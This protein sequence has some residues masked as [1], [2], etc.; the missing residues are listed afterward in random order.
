MK[1]DR[2]RD[3][4]DGALQAQVISHLALTVGTM[5]GVNKAAFGMLVSNGTAIETAAII[6]VLAAVPAGI[7]VDGSLKKWLPYVIAWMTGKKDVD[8]GVERKG[9]L[10]WIIMLLCVAQLGVSTFLNFSVSPEIIEDAAGEIDTEKYDRMADRAVT[11]YEKDMGRIEQ[12]IAQAQSEVSKAE[13]ARADL[14]ASAKQSK[15]AQMAKLA[16]SGNGWA[17]NEI[18]SAVRN[19]ER[20]GDKLIASATAKLE[21]EQ[22]R[23]S[24]YMEKSGSTLDSV[25][26]AAT[27]LTVATT[28]KHEQKKGRWTSVMVWFMGLM[29]FTFVLSTVVVVVLEEEMDEDFDSLPT[30]SNIASGVLKKTTNAITK[31]AV[32][33]FGLDKITVAP[34]LAGVSHSVRINPTQSHTAQEDGTQHSNTGRS[35]ERTQNT[36]KKS[37]SVQQKEVR[38]T[39]NK[40]ENPH[41]EPNTAPV[42]M[43][44]NR[45]GQEWPTPENPDGWDLLVKRAREWAKQSVNADNKET[46]DRNKL[47]WNTF[48]EYAALFGYR[49]GIGEAES[50]F[51]NK[52]AEPIFGRRRSSSSLEPWR[53]W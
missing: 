14:I 13:K 25:T 26:V 38:E 4:I 44:Q 52:D 16:A 3:V 46:R 33:I 41:T 24:Q 22:G 39:Q 53:R 20:K 9:W 34:T 31:T 23:L 36:G 40:T 48:V 37:C 35:T 7:A 19:A 50:R 1:K 21:K 6:A 11:H 8:T 5:Y 43:M 28:T 51:V 32:K 27:G 2:T 12:G 17:Q 45:E 49:A 10:N 42:L 15:G 29:A 30:A 18:A 47:R